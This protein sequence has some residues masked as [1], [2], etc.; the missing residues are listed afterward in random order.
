MRTTVAFLLIALFAGGAKSS[1]PPHKTALIIAIADYKPGTGWKSISSL[2]DDSMVT[3]ALVK[4]GFTKFIRVQNEKATI[5]GIRNG[6][7]MLEESVGSGEIVYIHFSCHGQQLWDKDG[8]VNGDELD[9]YDE[10]IVGYDA[11]SSY[12]PGYKGERHLRDDELNILVKCIRKKSGPGGSVLVVNDA[13]FSGTSLRG[14]DNFRGNVK[15]MAPDDYQITSKETEMRSFNDLTDSSQKT[16]PLVLISG[17]LANKPNMEFQNRYGSLSYAI[18]R[19]L[20]KIN[21]DDSYLKLFALIQSEMKDMRSLQSGFN[22]EPAIEGQVARTVFGGTEVYQQGFYRVRYVKSS[23][24]EIEASRITGIYPGTVVG[25]MPAGAPFFSYENALWTDTVDAVDL[26]SLTLKK[27]HG[28]NLAAS[29][30]WMFV[31]EQKFEKKSGITLS[32]AENIS[33]KQRNDIREQIKCCE[34]VQ[35]ADQNADLSIS[36]SEKGFR[37]SKSDGTA[38][39]TY[40]ANEE[41]LRKQIIFYLH[42][43]ALFSQEHENTNYSSQIQISERIPTPGSGNNSEEF[44]ISP[45]AHENGAYVFKSGNGVRI[46]L[47]NNSGKQPYYIHIILTDPAGNCHFLVP[48]YEKYQNQI[49]YNLAPNYADQWDFIF[50]DKIRGDYM[51]KIIVSSTPLG[52]YHLYFNQNLWKSTPSDTPEDYK[53]PFYQGEIAKSNTS[54]LPYGIGSAVL[55]FRVK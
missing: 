18:C 52:F 32:F 53:A 19:A 25:F 43:S 13:C 40:A 7:K 8:T 6:F 29:E 17:A 44:S 41:I 27:P 22:Q 46:H 54:Y 12:F 23:T 2:R 39:F 10:C 15:P 36:M 5:E 31:V 34:F 37:L 3:S 42:L 35:F 47:K 30:I 1:E 33:E 9:G 38:L 51:A 26:R 4:K 14:E 48:D 49:D 20:D 21:S 11:P 16:A 55:L 45:A 28:L 50:D 24:I